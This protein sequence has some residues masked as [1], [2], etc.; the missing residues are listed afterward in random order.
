MILPIA[1]DVDSA[2][3]LRAPV[4]LHRGQDAAPDGQAHCFA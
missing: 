1:L 4:E 3:H 2:D